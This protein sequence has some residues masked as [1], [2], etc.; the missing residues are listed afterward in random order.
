[1]IIGSPGAGK[2]TFA[3]MLCGIL[4]IKVYH[5]DCLFWKSG[6]ES[7]SHE[8]LKEKLYEVVSSESWIIDGNYSKTIDIRLKDADTVIFL[9]IGLLTCLWSIVKR[10]LIHHGKTRPDMA[11]GCYEVLR[12]EFIW[13]VACFPFKKRKGIYTRLSQCANEKK[14]V[15]LRSRKEM[16]E[17]LNS[18]EKVR[19]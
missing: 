2:S 6:W 7:I 8:E 19:L 14:V 10:R 12:L 16:K 5:I 3:R 4:N 18:L 9:D 1:M 15:I 17:F 11:E 13:Y